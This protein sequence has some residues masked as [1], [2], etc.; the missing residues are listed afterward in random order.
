VKGYTLEEAGKEID[1]DDFT[2]RK[3]SINGQLAVSRVAPLTGGACRIIINSLDLEFY[4]I[5]RRPM[6]RPFKNT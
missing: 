2:L 6:G 5:H 4:K 3:A 1:R